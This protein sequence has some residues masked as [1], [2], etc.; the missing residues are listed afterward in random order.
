MVGCYD[1]G[2]RDLKK[3]YYIT[4]MRL[5]LFSLRTEVLLF[6]HCVLI[7]VFLLLSWTFYSLEMKVENS[8]MMMLQFH[9]IRREGSGLLT[10][11]FFIFSHACFLSPIRLQTIKTKFRFYVHQFFFFFFFLGL[12]A[13]ILGKG[14]LPHQLLDFEEELYRSYEEA[15]IFN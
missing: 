3:H 12:Y 8:K 7:V 5:W 6:L 14:L 4:I 15:Y 10:H 2:E 1:L 11:S 13:P 9:L